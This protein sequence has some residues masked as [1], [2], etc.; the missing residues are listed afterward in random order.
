MALN[1]NT[2]VPSI[3]AQRQLGITNQQL[4]KSLERLSSGLRI[5]RAADDAAGLAI[6]SKM[7]T[8]LN[9][10]SQA[11]RNANDGISLIQTA[12]GSLNEVYNVLDRIRTISEQSANG[13]LGQEERDLID[14]EFKELYA[15]I[16][17]ITQVAN[18]NGKKLLDGS[19]SSA[20][21]AV[22][23]Q[24]GVKNTANDRIAVRVDDVSASALGLGNNGTIT[25]LSTQDMARSALDIVDS[26][27]STISENR[28]RLGA[29]QNRL[30][31]TI[32]NIN[33]TIE[34]QSASVSRIRDVDFAQETANFTKQQ[35]LMQAGT[36]ILGNANGLPQ[37][38]L[39]L[40]G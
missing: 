3:N 40:L 21:T 29:Q 34:N 26:A 12:E 23:L 10:Y 5:N 30:E 11:V 19:I 31:S 25:T 35:I 1:V 27:I 9:G 24:V 7:R 2:N 33:I 39:S 6:T 32:A 37:S 4:T 14:T 28:G 20:S 13:I 36:A 8:E 22:S 17:R 16:D 38:A 15:E 18:F